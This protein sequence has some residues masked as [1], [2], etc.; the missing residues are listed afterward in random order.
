[1]PSFADRLLRCVLGLVACGLGIALILRADL[2]AAPWDVLHQ[3]ISRHTGIAV[4][5]VIIGVGVV[6]L[7]VWIPLRERPGL[8]TVLNAVLIGLTVN[9]IEPHL[10][11]PDH[12]VVRLGALAA[13]ILAFG[14]GSGLYIGAGLGAGPRDGL[15]TGLARRGLSIRVARTGLEVAVIVA[16]VALGGSIG[17]GTAAFALGI[18]PVVQWCLPRLALDQPTPRAVAEPVV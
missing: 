14:L 10:T 16:G 4:G 18:G 17:L 1:M 3:G 6:V 2:G 8:G 9:L 12:V 7:L 13:G 11:V 5:T 15:M